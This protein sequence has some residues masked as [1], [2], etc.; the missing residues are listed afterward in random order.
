MPLH[1]KVSVKILEESF[2]CIRPRS[3][4]FAASFYKNLFALY[5]QLRPLFANTS[6]QEQEKKLMISL[7][8]VINNIRNLT[9]LT[10]LLKELGERHVRYGI[11]PEYYPMVGTALL[12]TLESY[13]G[14]DWTPE[15]KQAWSY[16]YGAIAD[17]MLEGK[18]LETDIVWVLV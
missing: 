2:A 17:L 9:Y 3:T 7:V 8:L 12:K 5:P 18:E 15:V 4:E 16:G 6:M 13:L 11:S 10:T 1:V 14:T